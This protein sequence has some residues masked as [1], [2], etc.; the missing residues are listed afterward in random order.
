MR[1]TSYKSGGYPKVLKELKY[2][3]DEEHSPYIR[4]KRG[5]RNL[6]NIL[7]NENHKRS[8]RKIKRKEA[9]GRRHE[10]ILK[11][12]DLLCGANYKKY[13]CKWNLEAELNKSKVRYKIEKIYEYSV[14]ERPVY[15]SV[16][17]GDWYTIVGCRIERNPVTKEKQQVYTWGYKPKYELVKTDKTKNVRFKEEVGLRLI[18]WSD[19]DVGIEHILKRISYPA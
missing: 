7:N 18:W 19:K 11:Y 2:S 3:E 12:K 16:Y 8:P 1:D 15:E 4:G 17:V 6:H 5:K 13:Y 9:R 10:K 14:V